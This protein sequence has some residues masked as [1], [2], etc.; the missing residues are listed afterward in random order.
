[1]ER[2]LPEQGATGQPVMAGTD[3]P[4]GPGL[5]VQNDTLDTTVWAVFTEEPLRLEP[6][7]AALRRGGP[8]A[9]G[10]RAGRVIELS[11]RIGGGR[12]R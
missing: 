3:W 5:T 11:F 1:M 4:V 7:E 6:F 2:I 12:D 10:G 8:P 9:L